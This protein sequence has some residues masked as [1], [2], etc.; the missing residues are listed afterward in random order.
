M[1]DTDITRCLKARGSSVWYV[2]PSPTSG[3]MAQFMKSR[4]SE[5]SSIS[6]DDGYFD[7]CP[8]YQGSVSEAKYSM[9][10]TRGVKD[11]G[12]VLGGSIKSNR[13]K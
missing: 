10:A 7:P 9:G 2:G 8:R 3:E 1:R 4:K 11:I 12:P 6:G 5:N 13:L